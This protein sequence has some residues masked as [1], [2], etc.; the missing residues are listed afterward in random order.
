MK[1]TQMLGLCLSPNVMKFLEL[2]EK[3]E[4]YKMKFFIQLGEIIAP[5][6]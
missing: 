3:K 2:K 5:K 1:N 6:F 4:H